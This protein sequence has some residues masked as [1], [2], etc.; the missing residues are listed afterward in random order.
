M[1]KRQKRIL[2]ALGWYDYRLHDGIAKYALEHGWHL[3]PDTTKEKVIPWGWQGDG[4]LA[5]LGAGDDLAEFVNHAHKPTVDFSFRRPQLAFPRVLVDHV[6]AAN[7]AAEHFLLRGLTNFIFYSDVENWAYEEGG[8][9]FIQAIERAGHSCT[10]LCWQRSPSYTKEQEQWKIKRKW[11]AAELKKAPKPLAVFAASDDQAV[12]ILEICDSAGLAV[13]E[14]VSI[15]GMDNSLRA[16]DAMRTPISSVDT[17]LSLLGYRGAKLLDDL[18]H[19]KPPPAEP[20]RVPVA[21]L[22]TRK[23]SDLI[24]VNDPGVAKGLKFLLENY[25]KLIGVDDMAR[26]ASMSRRGFHKAF[27]EQIGRPPGHELQRVRIEHAKK[28]LVQSDQK[29][30]VVGELCGY[31][32]P[33]TFWFA[34]KQ[35]IGMSPK[36]FRAKNRWRI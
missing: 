32:N 13:P 23:S 34:F 30:A 28:L 2:L 12:E 10:W 35:A 21:G 7:L 4:I 8:R 5:W 24:A 26:A 33:N 9:A 15:I 20:V 1:S 17:N 6:S 22:I 18:M 14:Q 29:L 11:L 3:C 19:G 31:Q 16:V 27:L 36:E 25:H